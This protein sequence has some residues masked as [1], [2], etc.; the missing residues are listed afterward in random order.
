MSNYFVKHIKP[1]IWYIEGHGLCKGPV[2]LSYNKSTAT[3]T[4][5]KAIHADKDCRKFRDDDYK[6][7]PFR[8]FSAALRYVDEGRC[9]RKLETTE[10]VSKVTCVDMCGVTYYRSPKGIH[11]YVISNP[12]GGTTTVYIGNDNTVKAN[13]N[14]AFAKAIDKRHSFEHAHAVKSYWSFKSCKIN[15]QG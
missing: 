2:G 5:N 14:A 15:E 3:W 1:G 7:H 6:S 9:L 4:L 8:S 11:M 12:L 10:R 13:L